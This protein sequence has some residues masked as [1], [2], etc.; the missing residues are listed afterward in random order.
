VLAQIRMLSSRARTIPSH[1]RTTFARR[2]MMSS[3]RRMILAC[4][5]TNTI[6]RRV[7]TIGQRTTATNH[8]HVLCQLLNR[9]IGGVEIPVIPTPNAIGRQAM[10][11]PAGN[12]TPIS[13]PIA[14]TQF[15]TPA[16]RGIATASLFIVGICR[17][18]KPHHHR[19]A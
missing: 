15:D 4:H 19:E 10:P 11:T 13:K 9:Q 6:G 1:P 7:I 5:R 3:R 8:Y 16:R 18:R 2:R 17:C 14:A 12:I